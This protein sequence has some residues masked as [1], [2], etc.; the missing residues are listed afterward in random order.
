MANLTVER[1]AVD[2]AQ[3]AMFQAKKLCAKCGGRDDIPA[4]GQPFGVVHAKHAER[5]EAAHAEMQ[6]AT[7]AY[8]AAEQE[9]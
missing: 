3:A 4:D 6:R 9:N 2:R 1:A 5:V 8:V 7:A